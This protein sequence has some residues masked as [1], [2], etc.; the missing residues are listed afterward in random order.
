MLFWGVIKDF[1]H[2]VTVLLVEE[3]N[4][5]AKTVFTSLIMYAIKING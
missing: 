1:A 3:R 4:I 5:Y 2:F